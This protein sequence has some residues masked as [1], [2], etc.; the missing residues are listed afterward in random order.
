MALTGFHRCTPR[1]TGPSKGQ[2]IGANVTSVQAGEF[3]FGRRCGSWRCVDRPVE[4]RGESKRDVVPETRDRRRSEQ[5]GPR[6]R[7]QD[8]RVTGGPC[9]VLT[10]RPSR[11]TW[12]RIGVAQHR[13]WRHSGSRRFRP[14]RDGQARR[15]SRG[16]H[17]E[18]ES[19]MPARALHAPRFTRAL[20]RRRE[21]LWEDLCRRCGDWHHGQVMHG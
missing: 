8:L 13:R 10:A 9:V 19:G 20:R 2:R 14:G 7:V 17:R 21:S 6:W 11:R 15:Q 12:T 16:V 3:T 5:S 1:S 18:S 4:R